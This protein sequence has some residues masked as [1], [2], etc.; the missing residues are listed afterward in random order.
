MKERD[1][2]TL[3]CVSQRVVLDFL[4]GCFFPLSSCDGVKILAEERERERGEKPELFSMGWTFC[5]FW[6]G[7]QHRRWR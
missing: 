1:C 4:V 3:T 6:K 7:I 5:I 2:G